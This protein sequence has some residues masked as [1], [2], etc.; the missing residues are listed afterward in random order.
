ML[1]EYEPDPA[2]LRVLLDPAHRPA[3]QR[4]LNALQTPEHVPR[5]IA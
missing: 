4:M 1:L 5:L 3:I 2:L